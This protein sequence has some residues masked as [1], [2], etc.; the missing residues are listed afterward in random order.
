MPPHK[1]LV[2]LESLCTNRIAAELVECLLRLEILQLN[3]RDEHMQDPDEARLALRVEGIN[4]S[5]LSILEFLEGIPS[6]LITKINYALL[7][8]YRQ[9]YET[10]EEGL[11]VW[12][13]TRG[14]QAAAI[15]EAI[16]PSSTSRPPVGPIPLPM[17]RT[18]L[19]LMFIPN[20]TCLNFQP[21]IRLS[22]TS[23]A[24]F[25]NFKHF[26]SEHLPKVPHLTS[27]NLSSH[28]SSNSLPQCTNEH[29]EL[30]GR[31]CPELRFLDVSFNK[32]VSGEGLNYLVPAAAVGRPG[33]VLLEK[34]FIFDTGIFEKEV[35]G[36]LPHL[37]HLVFLGYKETGKVLRT[38]H[39]EQQQQQQ[40][41]NEL[42]LTH[43]DNL[44]SKNRRLIAATLRCKKAVALAIALLCPRVQNIKLRVADDDV[45]SLAGLEH[46][47]SAELVYHV[48]SLHSPGPGTTHFLTVRGGMLTSLALICNTMSMAMLSVVAENCPVLG[49]FWCRSNHLLAPP[50]KEDTVKM[51]HNYL[52]YLSVL[53]LRVG[54]GELS[55]VHLPEYI[56]PYLLRNAPLKELILAVRSSTICDN[57]VVNTLL[58][59]CRSTQA[60]EKVM[61]VVPGLNSLPGI[62]NLTAT[63]L[64]RILTACPN[65]RKIGNLLSWK[66]QSEDILE[67]L[68]TASELNWDL[69]VVNQK[70]TMR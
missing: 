62:L 10:I 63:S 21:L 69:E 37:P 19:S 60:V 38:I 47:E 7:E 58:P 13:L 64:E 36:V 30:I 50:L 18:V 4:R 46:L 53:Y 6:P 45:Q 15:F 34:L 1:L 54:E 44:G 49:Q 41:F 39:R 68:E 42:N 65:I 5:Y 43:V 67:L 57:Y 12:V 3:V 52:T 16:Q 9:R 11:R 70:M 51:D 20:T 48:G 32:A 22:S 14:V 25:T 61:I 29:L 56:L 31:H 66:L 35:A 28:N 23:E 17:L 2:S 33:C 59:A 26:L 27:L 24:T 8:N 40:V 55:L